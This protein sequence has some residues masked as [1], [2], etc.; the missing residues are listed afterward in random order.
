MPCLG[1]LSSAS[2]LVKKHLWEILL[3]L[4]KW[5]SAVI[6]RIFGIISLSSR[7]WVIL[8][9]GYDVLI[10]IINEKWTRRGWSSADDKTRTCDP[11]SGR[12]KFWS[13]KYLSGWQG[14]TVTPSHR[15]TG[16]AGAAS[17]ERKFG[18]SPSPAQTRPD[19]PSPGC[20]LSSSGPLACPLYYSAR[21]YI[22]IDIGIYTCSLSSQVILFIWSS[23]TIITRNCGVWTMVQARSY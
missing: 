7:I 5:Y 20:M 22:T 19:Q 17:Q 1:Q 12:S 9:P 13:F 6:C 4:Y 2:T 21:S 10:N 18:L 11:S 8:L 15:H 14:H 3:K 23:H 16:L